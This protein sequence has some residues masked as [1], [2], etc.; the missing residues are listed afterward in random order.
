[1]PIEIIST[2]QWL[3]NHL[4]LMK[5]VPRT[6]EIHLVTPSVLECILTTVTPDGVACLFPFSSLPKPSNTENF[7]LALDRIQDPGNVGTLFRT[8]LAA[9][10][11]TIWLA[12]GADPLSQKVLRSSSGAVL[13]LPFKRFG[14]SEENAIDQL[15]ENLLMAAANGYQVVA[16]SVNRDSFEYETIPYWELDWSKP[17]VLVLGNEGKGIHPRIQACCT[18]GVTLP[19]SKAVESLNVAAAAVPLL[20]ERQRAKMTSYMKQKR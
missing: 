6:I 19:H 14:D 3:E 4:K 13:Q 17:T 11:E 20:L 16:T 1:M 5:L 7:V 18:I 2:V 12:L 8:A 15:I 10:V 9:E